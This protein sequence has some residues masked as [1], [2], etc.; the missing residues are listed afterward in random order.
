LISPARLRLTMRPPPSTLFPY[1]T[2]FRS[3]LRAWARLLQRGR[4]EVRRGRR[5][6]DRARNLTALQS[7]PRESM[8]RRVRSDRPRRHLGARCRIGR[9]G[10]GYP[11]RAAGDEPATA[12][13]L[14]SRSERGSARA[15][16]RAPLASCTGGD[17][18]RAMAR[19]VADGL[20]LRR[21]RER[22]PRRA[23]RATLSYSSGSSE[24]GRL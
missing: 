22:S 2:L 21:A 3:A 8:H 23:T 16:A 7:L 19:C 10:G 24:R 12:D 15:S 18:V 20:S 9:D 17:R 14:H 1:T 13:L 11:D 6:R 5:L 4:F